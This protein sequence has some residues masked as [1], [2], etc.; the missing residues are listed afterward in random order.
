MKFSSYLK[1]E[2]RR[3]VLD[4]S[5][6]LVCFISFCIPLAGYSFYQPAF[7]GTRS[8]IWIANPALAGALGGAILFGFF[9][10]QQLHRIN[11]YNTSSLTD[12]IVSPLKMNAIRLIAL[13]IVA[14]LTGI[15]VGLIYLP[16]TIHKMS[17][18][19][20]LS[21]YIA[22]YGIILIPSLIMGVLFGAIF[23]NMVQRFDLSAIIFLV[24]SFLP[25]GG[26]VR[27]DFILRWINPNVPVFSDGFSNA[28]ILRTTSY[29]RI[30][31]FLLLTGL[32]MLSLL[33]IRR[34]GKGIFKS[35]VI[36][37]K[38]LIIP[39]TIM[40]LIVTP[41]CLYINQP[42]INHAPTE[43]GAHDDFFQGNI[44][45]KSIHTKAKPNPILG[46][47]QG[48]TV[49]Q[50]TNDSAQQQECSLEID[51]GYTVNS[52]AVNGSPID[53]TDLNN[54]LYT[55]KVVKFRLP[56]QQDIELVVEYGGYPQIWSES[57]LILSGDE[58]SSRFI[59]LTGASFTPLFL[60]KWDYGMK[61]T[62]EIVLP[63]YMTPLVMEGSTKLLTDNHDGTKTWYLE[64]NDHSM[65]YMYAAD[66]LKQRVVARD[67]TADFYYSRKSEPVM[68]KYAIADT[69]KEVMD[70]CTEKYGSVTYSKDDHIT[71]LQISASMFGGYAGGGMSVFGETT[72]AED[73]LKDPLRGASG[74][75]VMAHEIVHQWW[76][77]L[78]VAF[79]GEYD[80]DGDMEWTG[81]GFTVYTTYRMMKEK[82]GEEYAKTYYVDVWK[83]A[84]EDM[85]NNF[86]HRNPQYT[87]LL[88]ERYAS[89]IRENERQVKKYCV[90]P[91]KILKAAELVGGEEKMDEIM[92]KI[93][94]DKSTSD[95]RELT[96][97]E[98]LSACGL[99]KEALELE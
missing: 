88:P 98:F 66:Y 23:Y 84:V 60:G 79:E 72:F 13:V 24:C 46:T 9:T 7:G 68:T 17:Y 44:T 93:Y 39:I 82:Y 42:F 57:A 63:S 5:T 12:V 65:I 97:Q 20:S 80:L 37:S 86:Y 2:L 8:S 18:L 41:I 6:W 69:L 64:R 45:V 29:N 33:C 19:F 89:L 10:I 34:Y 22:T 40:I 30:F 78:G 94:K 50:L 71:L 59:M 75:E 35:L 51:C 81:E 4:P 62:A 54:D 48:T 67:M 61:N 55:S 15:L 3:L 58:I 38:Q 95:N 1:V 28:L 49:Y 47:Q 73:T 56:L 27:D 76:G 85:K 16:F 14:L 70:F 99:T 31:W 36:N 53:F 43:Y 96:Y 87:N 90:M 91:L 92:G 83:A 74:Q 21:T 26:F 32:Y 52:I 11:K 25:F 77:G